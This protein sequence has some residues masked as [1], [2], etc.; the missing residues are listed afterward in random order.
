MLFIKTISL[1][2]LGAAET[3]V[4]E[5]SMPRIME[6]V[7]PVMKSG[8]DANEL[9]IPERMVETVRLSVPLPALLLLRHLDEQQ[10][11]GALKT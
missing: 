4:A 8:I 11:M 9:K 10:L 6:L 5:L 1:L 3:G 2:M 7:G